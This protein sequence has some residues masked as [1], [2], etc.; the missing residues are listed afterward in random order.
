MKFFNRKR[1]NSRRKRKKKRM[2]NWLKVERELSRHALDHAR[3]ESA[4][5]HAAFELEKKRTT[6]SYVV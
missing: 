2:A 5:F 3:L 4:V 1:A 6:R